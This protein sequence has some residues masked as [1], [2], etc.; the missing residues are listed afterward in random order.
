MKKL[1]TVSLLTLFVFTAC[2]K[3][4]K[5][6]T[7]SLKGKW[8]IENFVYKEYIGGALTNTYNDPGAGGTV[9]FQNNGNV[10]FTI[11]GNPVETS[12]YTIKPDSKVAIDGDI[13]E[14]RNLTTS[15]VTL[16]IREDYAPGEYDESY[17]NLK[18]L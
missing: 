5:P 3:D 7:P 15:N 2:K 17:I 10:V 11:P 14:V 4:T 8:T 6:A 1:L 18:R 9:D 12:P 13:F 16:F